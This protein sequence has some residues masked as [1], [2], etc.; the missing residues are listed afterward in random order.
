MKSLIRDSDIGPID[1]ESAK[2]SLRKKFEPN[3]TVYHTK[4]KHLGCKKARPIKSSSYLTIASYIATYM[5]PKP[6]IFQTNE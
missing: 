2:L 3:P 1:L 5:Q 4:Q 6:L